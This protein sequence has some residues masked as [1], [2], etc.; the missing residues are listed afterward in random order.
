[1]KKDSLF[2]EQVGADK[3][4][5]VWPNVSDDAYNYFEEGLE[6]MDTGDLKK[7]KVLFRK[8][9]EVFPEHIDVLHHLALITED[10]EKSKS[11]TEKAVNCGKKAFAKSFN[12]KKHKL[13]WGWMENRPFLRAYNLMAQNI[14]ED[15]I[16]EAVEYF[17]QILIWNPNDNQGVREILA[18]IYVMEELWG[19]M[20][21]L[22]KKYYNDILPS[23]S[24]GYALALFK[25]EKNEKASKALGDTIKKMPLCAKELLKSKH[26][27]P[28]SAMPG[29]ITFGGADQAYEF[30]KD[31]GKA[32][33]WQD[34]AVKD[35]LVEN[36]HD[37]KQNKEVE[38]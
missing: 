14:L 23:T 20:I 27:K 4:R 34:Q 6:C 8:A 15:D 10:E 9:L 36:L 11:L 17:K 3:W 24:Y 19:E 26:V 2:I 1:M 21:A 35:W 32:K 16:S 25:T 22:G 12:S 28:K 37:I 30:W 5:F 13:E 29:Y 33:A 7:A 38:K 18:D 31:Q